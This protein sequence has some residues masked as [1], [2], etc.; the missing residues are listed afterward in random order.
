MYR[1]I[2]LLCFLMVIFSCAKNKVIDSSGPSINIGTDSN[3]DIITWNIQNFPKHNTTLN[4]LLEL[5]SIMD[6]D[7]I[8]LQ[9]IENETAFNTLK[10]RLDGYNGI[11]T[12]SASY[13]INLALLYSNNLEVE[14]LY[15]IFEDDWWSFPR[16]PLVAQI[17]WN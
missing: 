2:I 3:L 8:A 17:V 10:D 6:P 5:I 11:I 9:E 16:P 14:S 4:Y 1:G 7:I 12:N 15:E 13:N